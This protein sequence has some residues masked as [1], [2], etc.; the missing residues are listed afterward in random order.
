MWCDS[1]RAPLRGHIRGT[2]AVSV[3]LETILE[4]ILGGHRAVGRQQR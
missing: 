4:E 1:G 3:P 2:Q